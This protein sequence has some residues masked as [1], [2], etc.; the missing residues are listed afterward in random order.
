MNYEKELKRQQ[1]KETKMQMKALKQKERREKKELLDAYM[2][3]RK[4]DALIKKDIDQER[5]RAYVEKMTPKWEKWKKLNEA[6]KLTLLE[7]IG[8]AITHGVGVILTIIAYILLMQ[9]SDTPLKIIA[10]SVYCLAMF[11]MF[12]NSCLYHSW[13]WGSKVKRIWRRFD[14]TSIYL[15]IA[16]TFAPLQLIEIPSDFGNPNGFIFGIIYFSIMWAFVITGI[17]L[18]CVFGPGRTKKINFPLY[19]IIGW[20][21]LC[22]LQGWIIH[23]NFELLFWILA[24]G[25]VYTLGMIPFAL[26]RG[27]K[28]AHFIWHLIVM[29]GVVIQFIGIY[30]CVY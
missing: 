22:V 16:G 11:F 30:L 26:L 2:H 4:V 10:S 24:G 25:I 7:E 5:R 17:T 19:F 1:K 29:A 8:N 23:K 9:K 15:M 12:F 20:S 14:Y 18:T 13:R 28:G 27:K 3:D 6:P 21:G